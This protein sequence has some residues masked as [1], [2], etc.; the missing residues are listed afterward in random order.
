MV[1]VLLSMEKEFHEKIPKNATGP[2]RGKG[3]SV[4]RSKNAEKRSSVS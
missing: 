4:R 2:S 3:L 1:K